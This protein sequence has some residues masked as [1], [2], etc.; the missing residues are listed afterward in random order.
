MTYVSVNF[1]VI[2][3]GFLFFYCIAP[4]VYIRRMLILFMNF[5]FYYYAGGLSCMLIL[6]LTSCAVYAG[7]RWIAFIYRGYEAEKDSLAPKEQVKVFAAYKRRAVKVLL[8]SICVILGVLIY[9]KIGK[10]A[11][12]ESVTS[13]KN[14]SLFHSI[15]VPLGLSYYTFSSV[16]YLAD[17]YWRKAAAEKSFFK[18]LT[19]TTFFPI[20]IEGP[21]T[22]YDKLIKQ[23][24]SL[25]GFDYNRITRGLQLML[26][27]MIKKL[28]I[29]DRIVLYTSVILDEPERYGGIEIILAIFLHVWRWYAD[30]SGC[31][32]IS[33]GMAEIMGIQLEKNFNHPFWARS[34]SDFWRRWHMT[35]GAWFKDYV[36]MPILANPYFLKFTFKVRGKFGMRAGQI[37][38]AAI[39]IFIVWMLTGLWHGTG[40]DYILWGIYWAFLITMETVLANEFKRLS[41]FLHI[42]EDSLLNQAWQ[43]IR[44]FAF[45]C[46]GMTLTTISGTASYKA[47]I[48]HVIMDW[49][50]Q[51]IVSGAFLT[52]GLDRNQ[53]IL[54][55]L[56][57]ALMF[58]VEILQQKFVVRDKIAGLALP[59]RWIVYACGIY[60]VLLLGF[61]GPGYSTKGFE[62]AA[63]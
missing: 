52:R 2:F 6:F 59:A 25:P 51:D 26:W 62:Y 56:S 32:D 15:I 9:A 23:F 12:W 28:V 49:R 30:F 47:V 41:R 48:T 46:A 8:V 33:L 37:A 44:T 11:G 31:I 19:A 45:F 36:Y 39:P 10:I 58:F 20:M 60:L 61:F 21:I 4:N 5:G 24:D 14:F 35:L 42:K 53:F 63:F 40:K 17:V 16:G 54:A 7:A 13:L 43:R 29:A 34:A 38:S 57:V 3:A 55:A 50:I 1:W 18:V 22:R 27:G